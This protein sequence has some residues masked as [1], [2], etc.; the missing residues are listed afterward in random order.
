MEE[1]EIP[2]SPEHSSQSNTNNNGNNVGIGFLNDFRR[3]NVGLSRAKVGCFVVGHY[4][5]LKNNLYWKKLLNYCKDKN[6]FFKV[7]KSKESEII[8]NILK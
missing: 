5:T 6:S 7:E 2:S 4:D 3:M 8:R 1:G